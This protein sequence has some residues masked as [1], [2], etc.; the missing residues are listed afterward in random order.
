M[1]NGK[2]KVV[3]KFCLRL[4]Y[5]QSVFWWNII[6]T[7]LVIIR[8]MTNIEFLGKLSRAAMICLSNPLSWAQQSVDINIFVNI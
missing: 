4:E 8:D 2:I 3:L 7:W 6:E 5:S 1:A